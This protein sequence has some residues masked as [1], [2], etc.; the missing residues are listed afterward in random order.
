MSMSPR[1]LVLLSIPMLLSA[2]CG[3]WK[4]PS[5]REPDTDGGVQE[6][7]PDASVPG[8][9]EGCVPESD[10]DFCSRLEKAC[11]TI[12]AADNCGASRTVSA[13]GTC[14]ASQTCSEATNQ[15]VDEPGACD[16]HAQDCTT[17]Q[18]CYVTAT[19][20]AC[21]TTGTRAVGSSCSAVNDCVKGALCINAGAGGQCFQACDPSSSTPACGAQTCERIGDDLGICMAEDATCELEAQDCA[22]GQSC[23][24]T[25]TGSSCMPTGSQ[26]VGAACTR[27]NDCVEGASCVND[28]SAKHCY[29]TCNPANA[30]ACGA[31]ACQEITAGVGVCNGQSGIGSTIAECNGT[32]S[33]SLVEP[34]RPTQSWDVTT[35]WLSGASGTQYLFGYTRPEIA[36]RTLPLTGTSGEHQVRVEFTGLT[37]QPNAQY[38]VT[39]ALSQWDPTNQR[40]STVAFSDTA[41]LTVGSISYDPVAFSD[42][43]Y[44]AGI[45]VGRLQGLVSGTGVQTLDFTFSAPLLTSSFPL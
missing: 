43:S 9:D 11:G 26:P 25:N 2:S 24:L 37:L 8:P 1:Y 6:H 28:G 3:G 42:G 27:V 41:L 39:A 10:Q 22:S 23:Y 18:A 4:D 29:L 7:S 44:C 15:C 14:P 21:M 34:N 38:A 12:T 35:V 16:V 5:D 36:H 40:W 33:V 17:G 45:I 30:S 19:S 20:S 13:C 31:Q 32:G